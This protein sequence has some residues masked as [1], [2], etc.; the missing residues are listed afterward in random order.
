MQ[1]R[2]SAS[3]ISRVRLEVMTTN[4][5]RRARSVPSSGMVIWKSESTSSRK[6][7]NS[8]SAR[9]ISSMSSTGGRAPSAPPAQPGLAHAGL[10]LQEQRLAE[11]RRQEHGGGEGAV[12]EVALARHGRLHG[13]NRAEHGGSMIARMDTCLW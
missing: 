1:R 4:G 6:A 12:G 8:S 5:W 9:S 7:S 10:A 11:L 2:L 3:W 13:L